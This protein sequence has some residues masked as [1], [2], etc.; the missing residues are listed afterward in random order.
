MRKVIYPISFGGAS[1]LLA[2]SFLHKRAFKKVMPH[3]Q[4]EVPAHL[5]GQLKQLPQVAVW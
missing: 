5:G 1:F 3:L 2:E 4:P